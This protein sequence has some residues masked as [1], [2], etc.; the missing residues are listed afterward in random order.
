MAELAAWAVLLVL[1]AAQRLMAVFTVQAVALAIRRRQERQ[2][3]A[4]MAHNI[5]S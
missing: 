3:Q 2:A 1:L 4:A 5:A